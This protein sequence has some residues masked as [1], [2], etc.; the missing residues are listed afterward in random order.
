MIKSKI[1]NI[2]RK[3]GLMQA[4][5]RIRYYLHK[6][7]M[8]EKNRN[9]LKKYPGIVLP[10]DYLMYESFL[11]D[12]QRYYENGR[13]TAEWLIDLVKKH[14]GLKNAFILDWGCG[15]ARTR[16]GCSRQVLSAVFDLP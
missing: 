8:K 1:S 11:L 16:F 14:R 6:L 7:K 12:Y 10:P 3:A 2:L 5:D 15:P 13:K 9:F 4:S